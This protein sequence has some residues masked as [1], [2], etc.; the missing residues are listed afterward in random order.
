MNKI[1]KIFTMWINES[2]IWYRRSMLV[3]MGILFGGEACAIYFFSVFWFMFYLSASATLS[4]INTRKWSSTFTLMN[5]IFPNSDGKF[6][7]HWSRVREHCMWR[8]Q[9]IQVDILI[10]KSQCCPMWRRR[11]APSRKIPIAKVYYASSESQAINADWF[12]LASDN[13]NFID[14]VIESILR[15]TQLALFSLINEQRFFKGNS[16]HL[17][18]KK[19]FFF[20]LSSKKIFSHFF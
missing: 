19:Q 16:N 13:F 11:W 2:D 17:K 18:E 10:E 8:L 3:E 4:C 9:L 12:F 15:R 20:L 1:W 6:I 7:N 5:L 14:N